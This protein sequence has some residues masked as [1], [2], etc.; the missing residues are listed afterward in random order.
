MKSKQLIKGLAT[1]IPGVSRYILKGTGGTGS[2]R[3]CYS[4]WMRHLKMAKKSGLNP[5]PKIVA[6]LGPGDSLGIGLSAL[7]SGCEK[8]FALDIVEYSNIE[9]NLMIF[10]ELVSLFSK[11]T[12][13]PENNEFPNVKPSLEDYSFPLGCANLKLIRKRGLC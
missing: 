8:Y 6:E 4:V 5:Y 3:Y 12:D 11:R 7:V 10:E 13:I 2:A 1:F 9:R